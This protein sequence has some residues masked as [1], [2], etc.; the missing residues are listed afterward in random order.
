MQRT[1]KRWREIKSKKFQYLEWR[2]TIQSLS[3]EIIKLYFP[4]AAFFFKLNNASLV[5]FDPL[6]LKS[7]ADT[8]SEP[9]V[10]IY[11]QIHTHN[12]YVE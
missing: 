7:P 3:E 8:Y 12:T 2:T 1:E 6:N 5:T 10:H 11:M 9:S 4:S